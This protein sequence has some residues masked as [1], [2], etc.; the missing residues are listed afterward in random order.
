VST[1]FNYRVARWDM[2]SS[3]GFSLRVDE[4]QTEA[5]HVNGASYLLWGLGW[6]ALGTGVAATLYGLVI[7]LLSA[8]DGALGPRITTDPALGWILAGAGVAV[9]IGGL[10]LVLT[11]KHTTVSQ[12]VV[13]APKAPAPAAA[14]A[15][16][17]PRSGPVETSAPFVRTAPAFGLPIVN[18]RF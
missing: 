8:T 10:V 2:K 14:I 6:A 1:A 7:E 3:K 9:A 4:G 11:N 12:D 13:G 5:L 15:L 18:F 17:M 16:P